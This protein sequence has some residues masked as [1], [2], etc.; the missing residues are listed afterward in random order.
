MFVPQ[1]TS[2]KR[3]STPRTSIPTGLSMWRHQPIWKPPSPWLAAIVP[4]PERTRTSCAPSW[5]PSSAVAWSLG[6]PYVCFWTRRQPTLLSKSSLISLKPSSW[7][8]GLSKNSTLWMENRSVLFFSKY[9]SQLFEYLDAHPVPQASFLVGGLSLHLSSSLPEI[10]GLTGK[11]G[12][13]SRPG[14]GPD[15]WGF[16]IQSASILS[17]RMVT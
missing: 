14:N 4:R 11:T 16:E 17:S 2:L 13:F 7:R 12:L 1:T 9:S 8:P 3:W 5:W 6:R 10:F 15:I